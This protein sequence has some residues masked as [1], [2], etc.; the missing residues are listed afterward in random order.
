MNQRLNCPNC[1]HIIPA[2]DININELVAKCTNCHHVFNFVEKKASS[3]IRHRPEI[4][5]PAG[6]ESFSFLSELH[7]EVSWRKSHSSFL[8]FF[9]ILW[10]TLLLPFVIFAVLS[11]E[12]IVLLG[13]SVHLLVGVGFLYYTIASFLNTTYIILD[14]RNLTIEHK[15]LHM[16]FYPE[17]TISSRD[18]S[19]FYVQRYVA[20]TS[21]NKPNYAF[22]VQLQTKEQEEIRI[23]KGLKKPNQARYIE[24]ELERFLKIDDRP[25]ESEWTT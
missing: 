11:G 16:P 10:N 12:I 21:N 20:S 14:H 8:T 15:P 3:P 2:K 1:S 17:R 4:L 7:I 23:I 9:T 13:I 22:A 19:Q 5:L 25:M 24:Q 18:I 6:I